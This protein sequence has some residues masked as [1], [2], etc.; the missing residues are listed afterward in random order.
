M[1]ALPLL[2]QQPKLPVDRGLRCIAAY[3][4]LRLA[5]LLVLTIA[6]HATGMNQF[7]QAQNPTSAEPIVGLRQNP[8]QSV[9]LSGAT[10][11]V[12]P[13]HEIPNADILVSGNKIQA[14]GK[15]LVA[16]AG[17]QVIDCQGR[18][19]Y[20]GFI[21]AF[22]EVEVEFRAQAGYWN[23]NVQPERSAALGGEGLASGAK[24]LRA[25]GITTRLIAPR[26]RI[27]K[28]SSCVTL[29]TDADAGMNVIASEAFQ[30]LQLTVPRTG[31]RP[32][33]PNSPMG[34]VALVRQSLLDAAWYQEAWSAHRS[35]PQLDRPETNVA[36]E[37]L[38]EF[39][40]QGRFMIDCPN[41]RMAVRAGN[42]ADEFALDAVLLGSGRE[43]RA[44]KE[45]VASARPVVVPVDF[46]KPPNVRSQESASNVTLQQL[47]H[48]RL[49]P[50]N[51]AQLTDSGVTICF[52]TDGLE[53]KNQ[54]LKQVRV[55]VE[56]GLNPTV[57]LSALTSDAAEIL[58]IQDLTGTISRGKLANL[59][60]T[61]GPLFDP[62]SKVQETWVA[63][64][65]FQI[66]DPS[67]SGKSDLVGRWQFDLRQRQQSVS[68]QLTI[69]ENDG[70]LSAKLA[71][72]PMDDP[73]E[74]DD[75]AES[76]EIDEEGDQ[77]KTLKLSDIVGQ[78]DR[79]SATVDLSKWNESLVRGTWRL[80]L[81][82]VVPKPG[83]VD[84]FGT[85]TDPEGQDWNVQLSRLTDGV[86]FSF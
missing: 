80:T 34:A 20:C 77:P 40:S 33:Y 39:I 54:F 6:G 48:W 3:R 85:M 64:Q 49:A 23:A 75:E 12:S 61:T 70:K 57:A 15:K 66:V 38:A 36:L 25:Q 24:E 79:L 46:P 7:A 17:A 68:A 72:L 41:E 18:W 31:S 21:D 50:E 45:I 84:T 86:V 59:V 76:E 29:L 82:T 69:E 71:D 43:Y 11:V 51:P 1:S 47:M 73:R 5:I 60:V 10:V 22:A 65:R 37:R 14:V 83:R 9:L 58:G 13:G 42:L 4:H 67:L 44:I 63:G 53:S 28:G 62:K 30:H 74:T 26:G 55:A 32:R 2:D 81:L 56:R 52:T 16:P 8:P 35:Q 19:I 27:I 78:R